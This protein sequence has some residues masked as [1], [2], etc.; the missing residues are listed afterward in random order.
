[1]WVMIPT[2][3]NTLPLWILIGLDGQVKCIFSQFKQSL[4]C[5]GTDDW[6]KLR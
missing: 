4:L 1:M 3:S 5:G 6:L 2:L